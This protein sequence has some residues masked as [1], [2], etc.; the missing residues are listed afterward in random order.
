[1]RM[2]NRLLRK[3]L[4]RTLGETSEMRLQRLAP[5]K[6]NRRQRPQ[7]EQ[8][9]DRTVPT[10]LDLSTAPGMSGSLN[11]AIFTGVTA[12]NFGGSS[13]NGVINPFL[14]VQQNGIEQGFNTAAANPVGINPIATMNDKGGTSFSPIVQ[15]SNVPV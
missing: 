3:W 11:G 8:L 15:L 12:T 2:L 14:Q 13:G 1:M 6:R 10:V 7:L 5:K 4:S 9:E